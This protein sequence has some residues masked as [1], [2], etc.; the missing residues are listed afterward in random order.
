MIRLGDG[1]DVEDKEKERGWLPSSGFINWVDS[2]TI[3]ETVQY[4][5]GQVW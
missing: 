4:E 1:L 5:K 2:C 3:Y